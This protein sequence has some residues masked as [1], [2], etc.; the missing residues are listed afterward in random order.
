MSA[1]HGSKTEGIEFVNMEHVLSD[2]HGVTG[3]KDDHFDHE[4]EVPHLHART[5]LVVV[6][7][8]TI[9]FAQLVNLVGSGAFRSSIAAVV[10]GGQN[11]T[12]IIAVTVIFNCYLPL[13][14]SQAADYFGRRW[15]LIICTFLGVIGSIIIARA[16]S[17]GTAIAGETI[18]SLSYG[19]QPLLHTVASEVLTRRSRGI[20]QAAVNGGVALGGIAGLLVGG[21]MTLNN[22]AGFRNFWYFTAG[23]YA[24]AVILTFFSYNPPPRPSQT[25]FTLKEK[26]RRLDWV[27][28]VLLGPALVMWVLGLE[29]AD[30]PCKY[31]ICLI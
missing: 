3:E 2:S 4:G 11:T 12:W 31:S 21:A 27:G 5:Y 22:P 29:W 10:G 16:Q 7:V 26:L 9:Y 28:Y 1:E 17:M 14:V 30:N 8:T 24:V 20:A 23:W 15:F 25:N 18:L 13:P 19:C 6:A